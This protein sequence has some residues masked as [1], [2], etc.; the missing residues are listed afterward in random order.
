MHEVI[1]KILACHTRGEATAAAKFHMAQIVTFREALQFAGRLFVQE[2][3]PD[4]ET[5]ESEFG[6]VFRQRLESLLVQRWV[7]E[8]KERAM[9]EVL[10]EAV[11]AL[12]S[13]LTKAR[14]CLGLHEG[15]ARYMLWLALNKSFAK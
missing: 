14:V 1:S 15:S 8:C 7:N 2:H 4:E 3:I 9:A 12:R 6:P 11:G 10:A 13:K 5:I